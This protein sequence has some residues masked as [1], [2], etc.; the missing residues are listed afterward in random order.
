MITLLWSCTGVALGS[1]MIPDPT[2]RLLYTG[3][4][5]YKQKCPNNK[6]QA[7]AAFT[8]WMIQMSYLSILSLSVETVNDGSFHAVELLASDQT[9]SLS[10]DG[11]PPKSINS[12]SKQSTLSIDSPLYLGGKDLSATLHVC[13]VNEDHLNSQLH[14]FTMYSLRKSALCSDHHTCPAHDQKMRKLIVFFLNKGLQLWIE[15]L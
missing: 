11:G 10:I 14:R 6:T 3:T 9:L 5:T 4:C 2:L 15:Q 7:D 1:A 8:W 12:I 13:L